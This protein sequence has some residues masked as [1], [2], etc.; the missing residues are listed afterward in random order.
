[1]ARGRERHNPVLP[2]V[3]RTVSHPGV[4]RA[5]AAPSGGFR[6]S[7]GT[8]TRTAWA[9]ETAA[10]FILVGNGGRRTRP[11]MGTRQCAD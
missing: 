9:L 6:P 5:A 2:T 8:P 11:R 3:G 4:V 7:P 1:M 10:R